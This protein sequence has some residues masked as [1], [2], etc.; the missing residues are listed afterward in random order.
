LIEHGSRV[1]DVGCGDGELLARLAEDKN[2]KGEGIELVQELVLTCVERGIAV[3]HRDVERGLEKYADKSFD[4]VILSQTVQTLEEPEKV[5]KELL[6][7]GKKVIVSFPN[8]AHWRCRAQLFFQGK[9]PVTGQLPFSWYNSPNKHFPSMKDFDRFCRKL[10][11]KV[12]QRIPLVKTS[13]GPVR[14]A[15]NLFAEQVIYLVS[16]GQITI[17]EYELGS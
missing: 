3:I 9:A 16:E 10:G 8:F 7:L 15:P 14:F 17:S 12:E 11:V 5:L 6:R 4:Y 1:L 2:T 13:V